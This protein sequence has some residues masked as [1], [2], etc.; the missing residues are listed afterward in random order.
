MPQVVERD[1]P[2]AAEMGVA[3]EGSASA[4][5]GAA[6]EPVLP[7]FDSFVRERRFFDVFNRGRT[8]FRFS[9]AATEP[10]I[11]VSPSSFIGPAVMI[12][13]SAFEKQAT[14]PPGM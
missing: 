8:P 7:R 5:P 14:M 2:E 11:R 10:W 6:E 9:A 3:I 12:D 13:P 4:W 1:I